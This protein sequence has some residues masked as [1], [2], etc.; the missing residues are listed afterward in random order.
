MSSTRKSPRLAEQRFINDEQS[1]GRF[2]KLK[3]D[4]VTEIAS[5]GDDPVSWNRDT[6][7]RYAC[8]PTDVSYKVLRG[9][10]PGD[11][12]PLEAKLVDPDNPL[13]C[14]SRTGQQ[15]HPESM[16]FFKALKTIFAAVPAQH[17]VFANYP[18]NLRRLLQWISSPTNNAQIPTYPPPFPMV[19]STDHERFLQIVKFAMMSR[20][21]VRI[22]ARHAPIL[23]DPFFSGGNQPF[24]LIDDRIPLFQDIIR[25]NNEVGNVFQV[26]VENRTP[27]ASVL[28]LPPIRCDNA[29]FGGESPMYAV[30]F[31]DIVD[32]FETSSNNGWDCSW[33]NL[34]HRVFVTPNQTI[35]QHFID[36]FAALRRRRSRHLSF[37]TRVPN[38]APGFPPLPP[39]NA[40]QGYE[41]IE[42]QQGQFGQ[43]VNDLMNSVN[44]SNLSVI[45]PDV[46]YEF[47]F[48]WPLGEALSTLSIENDGPNF[49]N[50]IVIDIFPTP[51][52]ENVGMN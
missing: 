2:G 15:T 34:S 23:V 10:G 8:T 16:E 13:C 51:P 7:K 14:S 38:V 28:A 40:P 43:L 47:D 32:W 9:P 25:I 52:V 19:L 11:T 12:C 5:Y 3:D 22:V 4:P 44:G 24:L 49:P 45:A 17:R 18:P 39:V 42:F 50:S 6:R 26:G 48:I 21:T 35:S 29:F 30:N 36:L 46:S 27:P 1:A 41:P 20:S 33:L 37:N 31:T